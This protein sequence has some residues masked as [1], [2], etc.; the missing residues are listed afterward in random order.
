MPESYETIDEHFKH[1][2]KWIMKELNNQPKYCAVVRSL[3]F[4]EIGIT[5]LDEDKK[6]IGKY[7]SLNG[8]DGKIY[9]IKD[10]FEKPNIAVKVKESTLLKIIKNIESVK[11]NIPTAFLKYAP[12][13]SMEA[14]DYVAIF[15][16]FLGLIK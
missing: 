7:A 1:N 3:R 15:T 5:V 12:E 14:K 6:E 2:K 4:N 8:A 9:E 10:G 16:A 11:S 13:F